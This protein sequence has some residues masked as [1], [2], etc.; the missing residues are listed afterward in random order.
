MRDF[1]TVWFSSAKIVLQWSSKAT[2][3]EQRKANNAAVLKVSFSLSGVHCCSTDYSLSKEIYLCFLPNIAICTPGSR[4][5]R[6]CEVRGKLFIV[7]RLTHV[8]RDLAA[9]AKELTPP[10]PASS[11]SGLD[12]AVAAASYIICHQPQQYYVANIIVIT[13]ERTPTSLS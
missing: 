4:W 11:L 7:A 1:Q 13:S 12:A 8:S 10:L 2:N 3:R 9:S 6:I 5:K